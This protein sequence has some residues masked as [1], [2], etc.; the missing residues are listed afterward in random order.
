MSK[1]HPDAGTFAIPIQR[2]I[3]GQGLPVRRPVACERVSWGYL[4]LGVGLRPE[5]Q[6]RELLS[7]HPQLVFRAD[8]IELV[9]HPDQRADMVLGPL[10]ELFAS[11][12]LHQT[13]CSRT[14]TVDHDQ[15]SLRTKSR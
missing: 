2:A 12:G 3:F 10:K 11:L 6:P 9:D 8:L 14:A 4:S 7:E 15:P 13:S 5:D 1:N